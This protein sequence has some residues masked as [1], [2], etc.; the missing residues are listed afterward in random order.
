M[1]LFAYTLSDEV[2]L[3]QRGMYYGVPVGYAYL[4]LNFSI[5]IGIEVFFN[6]LSV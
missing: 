2:R 3:P 1:F 4:F 6:A 5:S